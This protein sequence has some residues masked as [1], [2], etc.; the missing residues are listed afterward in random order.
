MSNVPNSPRCHVLIP[1]A[2]NGSRF[3]G[4]IPKQ[5]QMLAGKRVIDYSLEIF[6]SMVEISSIWVGSSD[7]SLQLK[8]SLSKPVHVTPTGGKT[9]AETVLNTLKWM[10]NQQIPVTDWVLVHDAARPGVRKKDVQHLISAILQDASLCGG[11]LA[12]PLADTLKQSSGDHAMIQ[13]TLTR[14]LL[15]QAQTPQMFKL[16]QLKTAI[17]QAHINHLE[18]TDEASAM[19]A[20]GFSPLLVKGSLENFKIT[21]Q[22][23][24]S[25]MEQ[26][27]RKDSSMRIGQGYDVHRLVEG[28]TLILGGI[29]VPYELGL[30]GHSDADA[31]LHAI[32]DAFLGASGLG[33]I[34]KHFPDSDP[35][36]KNV[37]SADL[38]K[39]TYQLVQEKG[40]ELIN[41]DATI[42]CQ[43]PKLSP[44]ISSMIAKISDSLA[45]DASRVNIKAKTNE[46]L[47]YLGNS[48]A[49][50]TQAIVLL[51]M[52]N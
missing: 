22:E 50:E 13:K 27:Y 38:L 23:D 7:P 28:R 4:D 30:L 36:Y 24:L 25:T 52:K 51:Q 41:L 10:I 16:G 34:G 42:I 44:Y 11:I 17:E 29:V 31:L 20:M 47:G 33:D 2:G 8:S 40:L 12:L 14:D 5:F 15:W 1:C 19:E 35:L 6:T 49:I 39:K 43:N 45:V 9:R 48:E 26:L 37:N 21:Y 46:G 18:I 32:T 3:G